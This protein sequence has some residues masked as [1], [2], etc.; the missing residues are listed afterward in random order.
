MPSTPST[1]PNP[2]LRFTRRARGVAVG[3]GAGVLWASLRAEEREA[4][5]I[6][7]YERSISSYAVEHGLY[8]WEERWFSLELPAP[9][10]TVLVAA[11]GVGRECAALSARGYRVHGFEPT[12]AGARALRDLLGDQANRA[13]FADLVQYAEHG[14][15]PLRNRLPERI[16]ATLLGWGA[17][18]HVLSA[19]RRQRVLEAAHR[20]T[21]GPLLISAAPGGG[22][23]SRA[24]RLGARLGSVVGRGRRLEDGGAPLSFAP[25]AG[26]YDSVRAPELRRVADVLGRRAVFFDEEVA[27]VAFREARPRPG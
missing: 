6:W 2:L 14:T 22:V 20:V 26:Y 12:H 17:V 3:F 19:P 9:P 27:R 1:I 7:L 5:G 11:A 24:G 10:A 23:A 18:S 13:S 21:Q 15:G 16:D 8:P 25:G 4:L